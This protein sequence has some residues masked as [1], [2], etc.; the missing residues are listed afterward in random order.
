ML[1]VYISFD[2]DSTLFAFYKFNRDTSGAYLCTSLVREYFIHIK[3]FKRLLLSFCVC[4]WCAKL[5][6]EILFCFLASPPF[7]S[8]FFSIPREESNSIQGKEVF[9]VI[10]RVI[11]NSTFFM[12][13]LYWSYYIS[14]GIPW[15]ANVFF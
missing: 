14:V 4:S 5:C 3:I 7:I 11:L 12:P 15:P 13:T 10:L 1:F 6:N 9:L 8:F 2:C